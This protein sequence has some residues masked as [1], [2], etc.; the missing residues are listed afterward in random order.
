MA[1]PHGQPEHVGRRGTSRH[2]LLSLSLITSESASAPCVTSE[3]TFSVG[4]TEARS[5]TAPDG[6]FPPRPSRRRGTGDCLSGQSFVR[7]LVVQ[8]LLE[9]AGVEFDLCPVAGTST[10]ADQRMALTTSRR[11]SSLPQLPW[12]WPPVKPKLR[13]SA[14]RCSRGGHRP[15]PRSPRGR[16]GSWRRGCRGCC[17]AAWP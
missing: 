2:V 11:K 3:A 7:S 1:H 5:L 14:R 17:R 4:R 8:V 12:K 16:G 10:W 6:T 9:V 13:P 15:R